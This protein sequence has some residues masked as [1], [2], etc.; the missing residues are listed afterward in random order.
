MHLTKDIIRQNFTEDLCVFVKIVNRG[1]SDSL[2]KQPPSNNSST[3]QHS[4][5]I[6]YDSANSRIPIFSNTIHT[7]VLS[8]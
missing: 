5:N 1:R 3:N 8:F 2:F 6:L 4:I 7:S